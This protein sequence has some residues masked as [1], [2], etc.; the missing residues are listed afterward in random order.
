MN[1]R[2]R[3][4]QEFLEDPEQGL[5]TGRDLAV[6]IL[7]I[8]DT[9]RQL[10]AQ[11]AQGAITG[12]TS[13]AGSLNI[14][15]ETQL[16]LDVMSNALFVERLRGSGLVAGLVS[17]ELN[18]PILMTDQS[19]EQ[20]FLVAF[21]PLDG[22]TNVPVNAPIGSIFSVLPAPTGRFVQPSD[23]MQPGRSQLAAGYA[24]Y[25]PSTM[26]VLTFGAGVYGFTLDPLRQEF[27][28]THPLLTISPDAIEFAINASNQ[29]YW[30]PPVRRYIDECCAGRAGMRE[31]DFNMRWVASMVADV[32]RILIRGGVYMY[33]QDNR[34]A[35]RLGRLRLMYEANP[36]SMLVEQAKGLASTGRMR[37]M[38]I[39]PSD[40][41][42][43]VPVMMGAYN[44]IELL[45]RYH[46]EYDNCE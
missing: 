43:R 6:L 13:S 4:L 20:S 7:I 30:E 16:K 32:H 3:G 9:V 12:V 28:L 44:E 39:R 14:Q 40:F 46:D 41:H 8:A 11:I 29:R 2:R 26:L 37:I 1:M 15:G 27:V 31:R 35:S 25:G 36:M 10:S 38:D 22:S 34:E 19:G 33:P 18:E 24:L 5:S 21:D 45:E 42:Q 17:E 23:F